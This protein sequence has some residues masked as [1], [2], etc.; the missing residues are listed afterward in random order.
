MKKI[1]L[2]FIGI[3]LSA[4]SF[5]QL[6]FGVQATGQ[7]TT[8]QA[9]SKYNIDFD[10][11]MSVR[12]GGGVILQYGL[13]NHFSLRSGVSYS[14]QGVT[15]KY[16]LDEFG[17]TKS[18]VRLNYVQVPLHAIY[19]IRTGNVNIYAGLGGYAGYGFSGEV[20]N[21]LWFYT[22]DGGY[23]VSEKLKAFDK[24][25]DDGGDLNRFDYGASG[26]AGVHLKSGLFVQAGYQLGIAN[27]SRDKDDT[28]RNRAIQL[29]VGFLLGR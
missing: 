28:Y 13:G 6:S 12:P 29:T 23:E 17:S 1:I 2:L 4:I 22:E 18:S 20:K 3:A 11:E 24:L 10:K 8:A 7:L 21:T 26:F 19:G 5:A 27:I 16:S 9:K 25:E 14:Q 15:L